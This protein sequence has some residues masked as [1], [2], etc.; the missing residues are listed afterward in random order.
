MSHRC[1]GC[2]RSI[3]DNKI[4][5]EVCRSRLSRKGSERLATLFTGTGENYLEVLALVDAELAQPVRRTG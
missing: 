2:T 4:I 5:C 1:R 3:L